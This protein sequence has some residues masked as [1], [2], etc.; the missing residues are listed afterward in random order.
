MMDLVLVEVNLSKLE[1]MRV[2]I[3]VLVLKVMM[4]LTLF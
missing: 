4:I 3:L 2:S 1:S